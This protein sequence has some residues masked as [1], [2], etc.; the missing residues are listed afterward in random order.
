[1]RD[2]DP[3][4]RMIKK[5]EGLSLLPYRDSEGHLTIG[6]GHNLSYPI[7]EEAAHQIFL[8]DLTIAVN[9]LMTRKPVVDS[10]DPSRFGVL[11]DMCFNLGVNRL[12]G[13]KK[14][15]AA[16]EAQD[17]DRAADEMLDSKWSRQVKG[18]SLELARI[19]RTGEL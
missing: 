11:A 15:W 18:R 5:H 8:D 10:L 4:T 16:I 13:F 14:M 6:W 9:E 3:I 12:L 2:D 7:S 19:M 1:M 17:W